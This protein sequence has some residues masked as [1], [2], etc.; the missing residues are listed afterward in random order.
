[1]LPAAKA[2]DLSGTDL[3]FAEEL[4]WQ[5]DREGPRAAPFFDCAR[6]LWL[7]LQLQGPLNR[8][9]LS[10]SLDAVIQRHDALRSRFVARNGQ[11]VRLASQASPIS[12][13]IID[14]QN[15]P[16]DDPHEI[17]EREVKPQLRQVDLACGPLLRA[18]LVA[19]SSEEHILAV[20]VHH[21]VFDRWSRR[22]LELELRQFYSAHL[23][24]GAAGVR[25]LPAQ[26]QD[27]VSWQR[28][29]VSSDRGRN[30]S[31][32]WINK[33][34]GL[35]DLILP[36]DGVREGMISAQCGA[37]SFTIPAEEV[38]RL[39]VLSR[40]ART[41]LAATMLAIFKLLLFRLSGMDDVAVGVPL[42]D[43]RRPE[44]EEVIGLFM[45]VVVVRT[46]ILNRMTFLD[47][48]D[49]VRRGLVDAC[50]HQDLPYGYLQRF[51]PIQPLYRVVFNFMPAIPCVDS[52]FAG[53]QTK[54][55][56]TSTE[57]QAFAD[58]SL[59][60]R[61]EAG[62]LVCR[63]LYK[64]DLFSASSGQ[65]FADLL[66]KLIKAVLQ[67]PQNCIDTYCLQ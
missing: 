30:L 46:S 64:T 56:P 8:E 35:P 42:S 14:R 6:S 45:N 65:N 43:R 63:F 24:G 55:I 62:T 25:P 49:R 20:A 59:H 27:Y 31:Q 36:C 18:A 39:A 60:L 38:N 10:S 52:E 1:M 12:F 28:K 26:Y 50:I 3:S 11:A 48:L 15:L 23:A 67:A 33:L 17:I 41:T 47:L 21:I 19:L 66:Q 4:M 9:A 7:V 29:Q 40:Q 51:I 44:F 5:T 53:L 57:L 13:T 34:S 54:Q 22:L 61:Y 58:L 37:S 32:Y 2:D 16:P